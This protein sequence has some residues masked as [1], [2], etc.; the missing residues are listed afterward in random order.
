MSN[1]KTDSLTDIITRLRR[2]TRNPDIITVCDELERRLALPAVTHGQE[3]TAQ[4]GA[5]GGFDKRS[6]QREYMREYRKRDRS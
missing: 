4:A 1:S 3:I 2:Q 5:G 6:Y